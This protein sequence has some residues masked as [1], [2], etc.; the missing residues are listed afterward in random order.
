MGT[1]NIIERMRN[2]SRK[3]KKPQVYVYTSTDYVACFNEFNKLNPV[4]EES[5]RLSPVSYG[6]QKASNELFI[7]DYTRK[8]YI[9]GR[10]ARISAVIGR[11]GW[12]NSIS[13]AY[14]GIFTQ[15]LSGKNYHVSLP[16]NIPYP[17]SSLNINVESFIHIMSKVKDSD[18]GHNRIVQLPSK[19]WTLQ[20]IWETTKLIS[21]ELGISLGKIKQSSHSSDGTTIKNIN[22][23]PYVD[24]SRAKNLGFNMNI[25]LKDIIRDYC[26]HYL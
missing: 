24:C 26:I 22:V 12:S 19:S 14:T 6:I 1:L 20:E 16:M 18:L 3:L 4:G 9:N 15:P 25:N 21:K 13:Y 23:C 10:V 5:F 2:L 7:C 17:C 8:G 11:P